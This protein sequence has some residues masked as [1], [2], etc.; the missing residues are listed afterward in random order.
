[1]SAPYTGVPGNIGTPGSITPATAI[2]A[3]VP[4]DGDPDNAATFDAGMQKLADYIA[5]ILQGNFVGSGSAPGVLSTGGATGPGVSGRGGGTSGVGVLGTGIAG[6]SDGVSGHANGSGS[7]VSGFADTSGA[8]VSG[9]GGSAS[10]D[11]VVGTG[12][13]GNSN[14][15]SGT[16]HGSGSG[17]RG[18]GGSGAATGPGVSGVGGA[19]N[20]DGVVG[21]G[22]GTGAG[23]RGLGGTS[24]PGV[25]AGGGAAGALHLIPQTTPSGPSDGDVWYDTTLTP[26][27]FSGRI[28]GNTT[29]A[30]IA[31]A[32]NVN[33]TGTLGLAYWIDN[34][35]LVHMRGNA[36]PGGSGT[37]PMTNLPAKFRPASVRVFAAMGGASGQ[38]AIYVTVAANGD[39]SLAGLG[40]TSVVKGSLDNV[41]FLA[42]Q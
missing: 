38:T 30:P 40:G 7:G 41:C 13:A 21:N 14:G 6:N 42:E 34:N 39:V 16:G 20:G 28:N 11:G 3:T 36:D 23:V 1:M 15:V 25:A 4:S 33:W 22:S 37:N 29:N 19:T 2:V 35:G 17:V 27:R 12:A 18:S 9:T 8:G 24:G 32:P 5:Y 31:I 10:G 26:P